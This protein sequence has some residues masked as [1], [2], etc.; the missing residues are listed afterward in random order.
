V[1]VA[2]DQVIIVG[3]GVTGICAGRYLGARGIPY[4]IL[5]ASSD[6]GGVWRSH[7]WHGARCD[8]D[9]IKY[10]FS[11]KPDLSA[12]CHPD[13][14]QIHDYLR[15]VAA[16]FGVVPRVRFDTRVTKAV[17][18]PDEKLWTVHT[19]RGCHRA[20][21]LVNGNGYFAAPHVPQFV[22]AERF[23]GEM[24][25]T[26]DLDQARTFTDQNVV[27]VGSGSTAICCA[28]ELARVSKSLVLLQR[29]PSYIYEIDD[30]RVGTATR[31][32]QALYRL[33]FRFPVRLLR[34][35]LQCKDDFIFVAFRRF[36]RF[37]R[38][39]FKRHWIKA[40]GRTAY[41]RHLR[42]R[43][44]PWRER[45]TFAMGLKA[46]LR[47]GRIVIKTG[48]IA[49]FT[50]NTIVLAD[51]E[52]IRCD[53]CVLATGF[54]VDV[55]KFD[56]YVGT[57]RVDI[58]GLNFYKRIMLGSVPNYFHPFGTVHSAWTQ[59]LEPGIRYMLKILSYMA[60][61]RLRSVT[62][63]R[64]E[65]D[66]APAITPNYIV[67]CLARLP[68]AYGMRELPSIDNLLAYRFDAGDF[69]FSD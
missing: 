10:S 46:Q 35:A 28:P 37:W 43:Y 41:E 24:I 59:S 15:S 49:R 12:H 13:S 47:S 32:C 9:F 48:E 36:P 30:D 60:R 64:I 20:R 69:R 55:L 16:E 66:S 42:P 65:V 27:L 5:E 21:F 51:G 57:R 26:M 38:W 50:Q 45:P 31:A 1:T 62:V 14:T 52:E 53:A 44:D 18:D 11:F 22:G 39:Y 40:V 7:R 34:Y 8:S 63:E 23:T 3:A 4:T 25:H 54:D 19:S 17:F 6:L 58:G 33:G 61:H 56:L 67:R 68:R 29:S 2:L